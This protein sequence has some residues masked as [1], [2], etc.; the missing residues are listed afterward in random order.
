MVFEESISYKPHRK[1]LLIVKKMHRGKPNPDKKILK[2]LAL[3]GKNRKIY[4]I[5]SYDQE[6]CQIQNVHI[7]YLDEKN[8]FSNLISA[9]Q[10]TYDMEQEGWFASNVY[11]RSLGAVENTFTN[12][13]NVVLKL[14]E[15]P[16]DFEIE[17]GKIQDISAIH[18]KRLANKFRIIGGDVNKWETEYYFKI[19][20]PYMSLI[21]L[22]LGMPIAVF[23]KKS[24]TIFSIFF[25]LVVMFAFII[26]SNIGKT[27]GVNGI[28]PPYLAGILGHMIFGFISYILF[29]KMSM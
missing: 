20:L 18:A 9:K 25:M 28:L 26:I 10:M 16:F 7:I 1:H 3:F 23:S 15:K 14:D 8:T 11:M 24:A 4:F 27:L 5:K 22:F 29:K 12:L 13:T 17:E 21:I 2:D 6:K 19:S